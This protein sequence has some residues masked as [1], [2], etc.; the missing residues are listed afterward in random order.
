[1][2]PRRHECD[3][4]G[5]CLHSEID[6]RRRVRIFGKQVVPGFQH[7]RMHQHNLA[8]NIAC[9]FEIGRRTCAHIDNRDVLHRSQRRSPRHGNRADA[10]GREHSS[11]AHLGGI[12]LVRRGRRHL[13]GAFR[14]GTGNG[15]SLGVNAVG[16]GGGK[17][18][19]PPRHS[20]LHRERA[21]NASADLVREPPK[22]RFQR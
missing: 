17:S 7:D 14:P 10:E 6:D 13:S 11:A 16:A 19:H 20:V 3:R 1:M 8:G 18:L 21:R 5:L 2:L 4:L 22:I 9:L 12:D 15:E